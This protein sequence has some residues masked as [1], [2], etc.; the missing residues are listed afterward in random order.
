MLSDDGWS[1]VPTPR[2]SKPSAL[3]PQPTPEPERPTPTPRRSKPSALP[4]QPTPEPEPER[5]TPSRDPLSQDS[6]SKGVGAADESIAKLAEILTESQ[7]RDHLPKVEPE[8]FKGDLLQYPLWN[9]SFETMIEACVTS[10]TQRLRYLS[11]Y[12]GG[13]A[14]EAIRGLL[15]QGT[16]DA[17]MRARSLLK[18]RYGNKFITAEAYKQRIDSWPHLKAGD[19][20]ELRKFADFLTSCASAMNSIRY[21]DGLN[22]PD[23]NKK[24]LRKLPRYIVDRWSR[25]VDTRLSKDDPSYPSCD[26]IVKEARI[27]CS[28]VSLRGED[29]SGK[30]D[31]AKG[32]ANHFKSKT[33]STVAKSSKTEPQP[34]SEQTSQKPKPKARKCAVCSNPHGVATCP[35]FAA[36]SLTERK[37]TLKDKALCYGCLRFGHR[38]ATCKTKLTCEVCSKLHPTVL[39][40]YNAVAMPQTGVA[41]DNANTNC[42]K[43]GHR[44]SHSLIL[45]VTMYHEKDPRRTVDVYALLDP[46]SDT[47]F[48]SENTARTLD[49]K[50]CDVTLRLT[51]MLA[52]ATVKSTKVTGLRVM[53]VD[54]NLDVGLPVTYTRDKIPATHGQIPRADTLR[55]IPHLAKIADKLHPHQDIEIGLLVGMNCPRLMKPRYVVPGGDNDPYAILTDL[56]WGV[57]GILDCSCEDESQIE[58]AC[59]SISTE[60]GSC[61]FAFRTKGKEKSPIVL[62]E[63]F[64]REFHEDD[65]EE[66]MSCDDRKFLSKARDGRQQL[67]NGHFQLP[68]PLKD[69]NMVLPNNRQLTVRRL[70]GLKRRDEAYKGKYVDFME[71]LFVKGYAEPAPKETPTGQVWYIPHNGVLHP[72]KPDKLRVVYDC[73]AAYQGQ[74]LN[75]NLLQGPDLTNNFTGILC[76][77]R[78]EPV[79]FTCDIE[80]FYHQV[81]VAEDSRDLFRF[82]WWKNG[83]LEEEPTDYRMTVHVFGATSSPG[84]CNYALKATADKYEEKHGKEAADFVRDSFYADDGIRSVPTTKSAKELIDSSRQLCKEGGFR[85]HK[86]ASNKREVLDTIPAAERAKNL[87]HVNLLQDDLPV[88]RTLGVEWCI[89][90]D[91]FRF[92]IQ[93]QDKPLTRR[94]ILSSIS[95]VFDP[96]GLVSPLVLVGRRILQGLCSSGADWD[97]PLPE[98]I[99]MEWERW[100]QELMIL[101]GLEIPRCY[102]PENF[103]EVKTVELHHFSDASLVGYGQCSY[104]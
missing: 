82:L 25:I 14:K 11:K 95:S 41:P 37:T 31:K 27:A 98:E 1:P 80:A 83:Q 85:L 34:K 4:P 6:E 47:C 89:Q 15:S 16:A 48:V 101:A 9:S 40:D 96:L 43:Q 72:K 97:D 99:K 17:Y 35:T 66:K 18:E 19:G 33:L 44:C 20:R 45:P 23:E 52:E 55:T 103:G 74:V 60:E 26:F 73:S 71:D 84:C 62:S 5:L 24:I 90:S 36:M 46:Q 54:R 13:E 100:R 8:V 3:P 92:Q 32:T 58:S 63:W 29:S 50:G 70:N 21:L 12:T 81:S 30:P 49:V 67:E 68:L 59:R 79:A 75:R 87:Q 38:R 39:H 42:V 51:T 77:F 88:E 7:R 56:G 102:K 86:F 104:L 61:H 69:D 94:G 22:N 2:R 93:L 91:A 10:V 76:R 28:P 78:K 57:I 53:D 65:S 64:E